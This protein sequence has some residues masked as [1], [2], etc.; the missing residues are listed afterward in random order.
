MPRPNTPGPG[1]RGRAEALLF[2]KND[3]ANELTIVDDFG[4]HVAHELH[5]FIDVLVEERPSMPTVCAFW[6]ARRSKRRS[7]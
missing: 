6:M 3:A 5:D 4:V 1:R 2:G 7:T